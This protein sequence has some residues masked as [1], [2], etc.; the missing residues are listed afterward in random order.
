MDK[1]M[2]NRDEV[3]VNFVQVNYE[4]EIIATDVYNL[5]RNESLSSLRQEIMSKCEQAPGDVP[6]DI[7][8]K[9]MS[10]MFDEMLVEDKATPMGLGMVDDDTL[11]MIPRGFMG[12]KMKNIIKRTKRKAKEISVG[13]NVL[14]GEAEGGL[15]L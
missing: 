7:I 13:L 3:K 14:V 4:G 9:C 10:F 12:P 15:P 8:F 1:M 5:N 6:L 2:S 11:V